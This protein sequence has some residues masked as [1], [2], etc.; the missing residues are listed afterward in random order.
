MKILRIIKSV[1]PAGGGPIEGALQQADWLAGQGITTEIVS[2]DDPDAP[3][4]RGYPVTVHAL[5]ERAAAGKASR[6]RHPLRHY[7]YN[8]KLV[9]WLRQNAPR[10]DVAIVEGLWNY[11][12][13]GAR[14]ALVGLGV[15]Y[16]VFS[17]GMLDP[18]FKQI[19]PLKNAAKQAFWLVSEGPLVNNAD[20]VF[21]TTE[22]E[23]V[24]ARDAFWPYRPRERVV[25]YGTKDAPGE[26]ARQIGAFRASLP[27]LGERPFLL[28]LSRIH[29][30]K[31]C[32]LLLK[33]FAAIAGDY[34]EVDLVMA[35]PDRADWLPELTALA[36]SLGID[37]RV[38]WPG[39]VQGD[40]KWG[41]LRAAEAFV[42]P[43]HQE[44]FG[45]AVAE[46]MAA[47]RPVLISNKVNIWREVEQ[48][49]GGLVENDDVAGTTR[50]LRRFLEL[51]PAQRDAMGQAARAGFL[52]YFEVGR[53]CATI[54]GALNDAI[55]GRKARSKAAA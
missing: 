31:G 19:S 52:E 17:H 44:N 26:P 30:K 37:G 9:P 38:H 46:S 3:F 13:M 29:P 55:A 43:S 27:A 53:A 32:D 51:A 14:R 7:G 39:M 15:P 10:Y 12:V 41:A 48:V 24:L 49:G 6:W 11:S 4:L 40:V 34:P 33:G 25:G 5:G 42:L 16:V 35:G 23:R 50:M 20:L 21:F 1:N 2:L 54:L 18:W 28:F 8:A 47:G 22:E 45:V 36:K